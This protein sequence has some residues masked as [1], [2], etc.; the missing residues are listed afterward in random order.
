MNQLVR[1]LGL[2][3]A[4][5]I[6]LGS[7]LGAG[8]FVAFGPAAEAAGGWVLLS[9]ALAGA[10]ALCNALSSARLAARYPESGGT[11]VY[12]TRQLGE[13]WGYLAGVAFIAGKLAS[14]A[15]IAMTVGAHLFPDQARLAAIAAVVVITALNLRGVH[16]SALATRVIVALVLTALTLFVVGM[17]VPRL[18]VHPPTGIAYEGEVFAPPRPGMST[19]DILLGASRPLPLRVLAGAGFLFFAFAGYAR[20]A[21]LGEEVR[22]PKVT[23][24]RAI[25][26]ALGVTLAAYALVAVAMQRSLGWVPTLDSPLAYAAGFS[27]WAPWLVPLV[28]I[29]AVVAALGSLLGL[30][31]GVSRT[32]L[33]MSR[34]GHLPEPLSRIDAMGVPFGAELAVGAVVIAL[35]S[36]ADLRGAIGF[37]SFLVLVYYA[38]ANASAFS[39]DRRPRAR[40][41]PALGL[42]GCLAIAAVLPVTAV[43]VGL[44]I[45]V[46][47]AA[48][49][50]FRSAD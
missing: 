38:I 42:I 13:F 49:F 5:V 16:R 9:L 31:L 36:V 29:A 40:I 35:V 3:D 12:G 28:R 27:A 14:C 44:G 22:N 10:V 21:T 11:Y 30:V 50:M 4:V 19:Q 33:A 7:M 37:S 47:G 24:P 18:G 48:V 8:V 34:D 20:I 26:I 41:V 23:I 45:L 15:A 17:L 1:R 2:T 43:V 32:T 39:L 46:V 6:G 25:P